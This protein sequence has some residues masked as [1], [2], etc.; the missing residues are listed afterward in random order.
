MRREGDQNP[1]AETTL[2]DGG[3]GAGPE[4][5][6]GRGGEL[7]G[8]VAGPPQHLTQEG[9][10]VRGTQRD[11]PVTQLL[12]QAAVQQAQHH[13]VGGTRPLGERDALWLCPTHTPL[14]T[15]SLLLPSAPAQLRPAHPSCS[16]QA[17]SGP[18]THLLVRRLICSLFS[19]S[20][21]LASPLGVGEWY[22]VHPPLESKRK[23]IWSCWHRGNSPIR[24]KWKGISWIQAS[25]R[26]SNPK[27]EGRKTRPTLRPDFLSVL[28][29]P[30]P[31]PSGAPSLLTIREPWLWGQGTPFLALAQLYQVFKAQH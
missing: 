11:L 6:L 20:P 30:Y 25:P 7:T 28:P 8:T 16:S 5:Y 15:K 21:K 9:S 10:L 26:W 2:W 22:K 18:I 1:K 24:S 27:R 14:S 31:L 23:N 29:S 17:S 19:N 13:V 3:K 4:S 12:P